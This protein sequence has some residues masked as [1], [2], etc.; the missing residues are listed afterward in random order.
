MQKRFLAG[1]PTLAAWL[2]QTR[3]QGIVNRFA[4]TVTGRMRRFPE[5]LSRLDS[6]QRSR[7]ERQIVNHTV[8]GTAADIMKIAM[9][10]VSKLIRQWP[11]DCGRLVLLSSIH[12]E[13]LLEADEAH[14]KKAVASVHQAMTSQVV[15][16]LNNDFGGWK[17][18]RL[19][20]TAQVGRSWGSMAEY[21]A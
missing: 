1:F 15:A 14:V 4:S 21:S 9:V 7:V 18:V 13:L 8:Q 16:I 17:H 12:D 3:D 19:A 11:R 5:L 2:K 6:S 20:A 10:E